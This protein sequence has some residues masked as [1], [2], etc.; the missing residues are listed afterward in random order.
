[1]CCPR[2][3]S[4]ISDFSVAV[5]R[6]RTNLLGVKPDDER[7]DVDHLLANTDVPLADEDTGVVDGLGEAELVDLGLQTT[8]HEVL[9][10]WT[11]IYVELG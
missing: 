7:R 9:D 6:E 3:T 11:K 8:L 2:N 4:G 1:M 10:L 5:E